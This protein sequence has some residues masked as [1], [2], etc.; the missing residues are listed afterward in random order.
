MKDTSTHYTTKPNEV[1]RYATKENTINDRDVPQNHHYECIPEYILTMTRHHC[2]QPCCHS[3][4]LYHK[5][6]SICSVPYSTFSRSY[7][8]PQGITT[9]D[10]SQCTCSPQTSKTVAQEES[11]IPL[12]AS[13]ISEESD[14]LKEKSSSKSIMIG[15]TRRNSSSTTKQKQHGFLS[16]LRKSSIL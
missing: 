9:R 5:P 14:K 12:L 11:S 15:W 10:N 3:H 6:N 8:V 2:H 16:Q 13:A 4:Q 1:S 7:L